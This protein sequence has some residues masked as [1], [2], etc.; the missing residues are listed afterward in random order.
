MSKDEEAELRC[1]QNLYEQMSASEQLKCKD[2]CH[3]NCLGCFKAN[4]SK[5]CVKCRYAAIREN[6][7]L[8]CLD[9]CPIGFEKNTYKNQCDGKCL[10]DFSL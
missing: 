4:S 5:S 1:S 9:N 7:K 3:E 6:E 8:V 2:L 10:K